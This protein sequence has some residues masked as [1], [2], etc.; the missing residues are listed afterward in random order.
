MKTNFEPIGYGISGWS[1]NGRRYI[2]LKLD[3]S[4][5]KRMTDDDIERKI[6]LFEKGLNKNLKQ[7]YVVCGPVAGCK[8]EE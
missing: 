5:L 6:Y 4:K 7:K 1:K 2:L 8:L 3:L